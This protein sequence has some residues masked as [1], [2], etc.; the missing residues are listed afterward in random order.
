MKRRLAVVLWMAAV[1][2]LTL[3][4]TGPA[5]AAD[6]VVACNPSGHIRIAHYL[7]AGGNDYEL[8]THNCLGVDNSSLYPYRARVHWHCTRNGVAWD[9]CRINTELTVQGYTG[10]WLDYSTTVNDVSSPGGS[11]DP[12][13]GAGWFDDSTT[14]VSFN[15]NACGVQIRGASHDPDNARF[16]LADGTTKLVDVT[17]SVSGTY[18]TPGCN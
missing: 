13:S 17:N 8:F 11:Y 2:A 5:S 4:P 18:N 3:I 6:T 10:A 7:T 9:G 1:A 15:T 14:Y 16:R 12:N